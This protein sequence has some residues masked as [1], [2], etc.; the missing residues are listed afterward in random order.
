MM[1]KQFEEQLEQLN[2]MLIDLGALLETVIVLATQALKEQ[3]TQIAKKVI[4]Y[5]QDIDQKEKE[6]EALCIRLLY[7]QQPLASDLRLVSSTLKMITDMERIGDQAA[8]IAE[9]T[10]FLAGK[11]YIKKL[12]HI[13]LMAEAAAKMVTESIDAFVKKDLDLAKAVIKHDDVV[14][15]LF[16]TVRHELMELIRVDSANCEQAMDLLMIAKYFERIA[17]HAENLAGWVAF[18]ITGKHIQKR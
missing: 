9:I 12:V 8:D 3:D 13:P 7:K 2:I 6:I 11:P 4:A 5:E 16:V 10:T 18:S 15:D 14:D 1:R 17:D